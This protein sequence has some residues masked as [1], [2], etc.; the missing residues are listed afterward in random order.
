MFPDPARRVV[1]NELV[2]EGCGDCSVKSNCLSVEP[3]ETEFGRKRQINQSS[4][5]KDYSCL[6]GFCP[7]FVTVEGGSSRRA[8]RSRRRRYRHFPSRQVPALRERGMF[9]I[10]VT[11]VGGTGVVTIGQL[12]GMAAH[13]EGRGVSVLDMAGLAQ[14]G[15][16]VFSHVQIAPTPRR[17]LRD[18]HRDGRSRRDPGLRP[19]RHHQQRGAVEDPVR[20]RR[21]RS[22]TRRNRRPRSSCA[23]RTG[24]FGGGGLAQQV[25]DAVSNDAD[26]R[27][28][29]RMR[30]RPHRWATRSIPTRSCSGYRLAEGLVAARPRN[31]AACDRA[32]RGR[33]ATRTRRRSNGAAAPRT[34]PRPSAGSLIRIRTRSSN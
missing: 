29:T 10:V 24:S 16:A 27:S 22:S 2:C 26:A 33:G 25:R 15:G 1:I 30:S 13:L 14:K 3:L 34:T 32:Q 17:S 8:R 6:N 28:S 12:L 31:T 9:G 18:A 11:G 19:D 23:I 20:A 5:N 4:C 21:A 7:S